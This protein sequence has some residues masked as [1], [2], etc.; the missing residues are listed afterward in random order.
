MPPLR[1]HAQVTSEFAEARAWYAERSV[2]AA[3]NFSGRFD[4]ALARVAARPTSHA[5]WRS[6]F[7]RA[8][9]AHFPYLILFHVSRHVTSVLALAHKRRDPQ[10]MLAEVRTRWARFR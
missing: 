8:R 4:L 3:D 5:P 10:T 6:I 7:R 1:V 9:V 2:R